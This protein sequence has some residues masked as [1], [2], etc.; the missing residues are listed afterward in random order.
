[1]EM[2][3]KTKMKKMRKKKRILGK[4]YLYFKPACTRLEK[5]YLE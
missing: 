1:M 3:K 4:C 2:K 5:S